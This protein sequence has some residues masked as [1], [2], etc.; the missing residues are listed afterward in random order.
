MSLEDDLSKLERQV[1]SFSIAG[2]AGNFHTG[3]TIGGDARGSG[4]GVQRAPFS[5]TPEERL[6]RLEKMFHGLRIMGGEGVNVHGSM[7]HGYA[8][9]VRP[10]GADSGTGSGGG[11]PTPTGACCIGPDCFNLTSDDCVTMGGTY[12][13]DNLSCIPNPCSGACCM[14]DNSC[15]IFSPV[16][17]ANAGGTYQGDGTTCDPNP[18]CTPGDLDYFSTI[19]IDVSVSGSST[20]TGTFDCTSSSSSGSASKT[21]TRAARGVGAPADGTFWLYTDETCTEQLLSPANSDTF[22]FTDTSGTEPTIS[23]TGRAH[24][25]YHVS[26]TIGG[27]LGFD[28]EYVS[29]TPV[30]CSAAAGTGSTIC[31]PSGDFFGTLSA[32]P[33]VYVFSCTYTNDVDDGMGNTRHDSYSGTVT[34]TIS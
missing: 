27:A 16:D 5:G 23:L 33:G 6:T 20:G 30:S 34:I 14:S 9:E 8:V 4:A 26:Q 10:R 19:T 32:L 15:S 13:G 18:C 21:W 12:L 7:E 1:N 29:G 17:C 2:A 24:I 22:E 25:E 31:S 3:F 11:G 28:F